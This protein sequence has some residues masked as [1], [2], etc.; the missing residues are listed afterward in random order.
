MLVSGPDVAAAQAPP[1]APAQ[2][3]VDSVVRG[4]VSL[5]WDPPQAAPPDGYLLEGGF[6]PGEVAG[7]LAL[8]NGTTATQVAL[9]AGVYFI[10]TFAVKDGVRSAASNEVRVSVGVLEL[11]SR[12]EDFKGLVV[13]HGVTLS[14]RQPFD[15]GTPSDVLLDV[16]G[17]I[18]GSFPVAPTGSF[19]VDGAPDG[20]YTLRLRASNVAGVSAATPPI[21]FTVPGRVARVEHGPARPPGDAGLPVRYERFNA[22]RIEQLAA[23]EGLPAVV[24]GAATEFEAVLRLKE[25]VAAQFPHTYPDPY[26][27]WDALI[28]LDAIRG[29]LT[30]GFCAQ[31]SQV[32]L[33][34]LA[35]L[36][37]PARYVEIG[38]VDNPYAHYPIEFW[39]N[40]FNKWVLLDA[41]FNLHF[42]RNGV[43][44]S[45]LDVHDAVLA[46]TA[47]AVEV[48]EG[49][50]RDGHPSPGDWPH[51]TKELYYY[52]RYHL[53][54]DHVAAPFEA[55]F[56]RW[57]DMIEFTDSRTT[58]WESSK[59]ASPFPKEQLTARS[60]GDRG[61]AGAPLNQLWVTPRVTSGTEVLLDL[62]HNMPQIAA[63]E[64]RVIDSAGHP[65]P[66]Q[67]HG[68]P[69]LIW[70]VSPDDR[71]IEV[72]GVNLR[73]I[74]GPATRVALVA[75]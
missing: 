35:A 24:S 59:V 42:E 69:L 9:P 52:V 16:Q 29:G 26:P 34:S 62:A 56:D 70:P 12:P 38:P 19:R 39:S 75:P 23:R 28:V 58:P 65:G 31:Y 3:S 21:T 47:D 30:G 7:S 51:G 33:Q 37:Y 25:W 36:G 15:G 4:V 46:G 55:A 53:K 5:S 74:A 71:A 73:G 40:Q 50:F 8:G 41:D 72:R 32:L 27:P 66:W 45:A 48:V 22:A 49:A 60:T 67:P 14:W 13:G 2:L 61:V 18:N 6:A 43:P 10:R 64:Y 68:S 11:P 44:L 17:P 63:A 1:E 20:V 54:A 57:G